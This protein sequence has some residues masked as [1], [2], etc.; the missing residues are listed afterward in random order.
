[1]NFELI[2]HSFYIAHVFIILY[3]N[4]FLD[5]IGYSKCNK[6]LSICN[7][8]NIIIGTKFTQYSICGK[9]RGGSAIYFDVFLTKPVGVNENWGVERHPLPLPPLS[10]Q[11]KHWT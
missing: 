11:I 2:L 1:M 3:I 9:T 5:C 8:T 6:K 4:I 7:I 10:R